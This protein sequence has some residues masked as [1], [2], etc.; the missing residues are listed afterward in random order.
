MINLPILRQNDRQILKDIIKSKHEPAKTKLTD[1]YDNI[2]AD[3]LEFYKNRYTLERMIGDTNIDEETTKYLNAAYVSGKVIDSVKSKITEIMPPAIKEKCP[4]CMLS[5]P[6]TFDHYLGKGKFPE[7]SVLS[8][9]LVPCC[10]KCNSKKGEKFLSENG[11]RAF[12][13]FYFDKLPQRSFFVVELDIDE[14]VPY[15]KNMYTTSNNGN[16]IDEII[17]THFKKLELFDRYKEPMSNRLASLISKIDKSGHS[18]EDIIE[19][20]E[21]EITALEKIYGTSYW[22]CS[23]YRGIVNNENILDYLENISLSGS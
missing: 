22:E 9:N 16:N 13:S 1:K 12:I 14:D 8:K 10:S 19:D 3:Y 5:E 6:G 21:S 18:R 20:L 4:H 17:K 15:I 11:N 2:I 23:L 7:Y